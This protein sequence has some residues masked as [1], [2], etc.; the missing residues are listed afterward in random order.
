MTYLDLLKVLEKMD[1]EALNQ[2]VTISFEDEFYPAILKSAED[3]QSVLDLGHPFFA[4][5]ENQ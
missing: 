5:E 3:N 2:N 1:K 4:I